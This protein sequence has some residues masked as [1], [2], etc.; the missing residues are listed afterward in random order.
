M[1]WFIGVLLD[2]IP[3]FIARAWSVVHREIWP[4]R[5]QG[6]AEEKDLLSETKD[7]PPPL[8]DRGIGWLRKQVGS[9]PGDDKPEDRE[10]PPE[11]SVG[12]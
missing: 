1:D 10:Q 3:W 5:L 6:Q 11:N 4:L 9:M 2:K 7:L 8:L 12:P